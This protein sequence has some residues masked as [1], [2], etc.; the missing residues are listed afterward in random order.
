ML[1]N[2]QERLPQRERVRFS[3]PFVAQAKFMISQARSVRSLYDVIVVAYLLWAG[4]PFA[5]SFS[6]IK[7]LHNIHTSQR[8]KV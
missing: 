6:S 7:D 2:S 1:I 4:H 3:S 8:G 5:S